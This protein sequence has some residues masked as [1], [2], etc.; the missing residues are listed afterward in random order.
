VVISHCAVAG[1]SL[2][3]PD[4]QGTDQLGDNTIRTLAKNGGVVCAYSNEG[5]H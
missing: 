1:V 4:S 2:G 5:D 3:K